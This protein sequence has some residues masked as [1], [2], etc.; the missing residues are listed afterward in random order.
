MCGGRLAVYY[1]RTVNVANFV[2][3]GVSAAI[4]ILIV[5]RLP[6]G[7]SGRPLTALVWLDLN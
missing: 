4:V 2:A 5:M 6:V 7:G 1:G 3:A